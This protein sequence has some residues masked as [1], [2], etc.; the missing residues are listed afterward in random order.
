MKVSRRRRFCRGLSGCTGLIETARPNQGPRPRC[1]GLPVSQK[2]SAATEPTTETHSRGM[3][4]A[5]NTLGLPDSTL[6]YPLRIA[7]TLWV[8]AAFQF[9]VKTGD[10]MYARKGVA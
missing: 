7:I 3:H 10:A 9:A 5:L 2:A 1:A 6:G 4:T 8:G